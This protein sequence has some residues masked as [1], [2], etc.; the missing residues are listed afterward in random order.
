MRFFPQIHRLPGGKKSTGGGRGRPPRRGK[1]PDGGSGKIP[2]SHSLDWN[3]PSAG[4][5]GARRSKGQLNHSFS[6]KKKPK[7][8]DQ[9]IRI[10][11]GAGDFLHDTRLEVRGHHS[12]GKNGQ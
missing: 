8:S 12:A 7:I 5:L 6:E 9:T 11:P 1:T 2:Q 4:G 3:A 10:K